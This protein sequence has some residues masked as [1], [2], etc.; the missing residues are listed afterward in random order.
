LKLTKP[1]E[2]GA[3][4]LNSVFGGPRGH[5]GVDHRSYRRELQRIVEDVRAVSS[6]VEIRGDGVAMFVSATTR[7]RAVEVSKSA[8]GVWVEFWIADRDEPVREE[9][10]DSYSEATIAACQ[11]LQGAS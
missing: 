4:Q 3:S 8:E 6:S 10:F 7:Q 1:G 11:W 9:A 5:E 2:D